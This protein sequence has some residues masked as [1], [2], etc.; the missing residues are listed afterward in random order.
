[1]ISSGA[2]EENDDDIENGIGIRVSLSC[3]F[4]KNVNGR[5]KVQ[6]HHQAHIFPK[7]R[8]KTGFHQDGFHFSLSPCQVSLARLKGEEVSSFLCGS[9]PVMAYT[10][11]ILPCLIV[12]QKRGGQNSNHKMVACVFGN[13]NLYPLSLSFSHH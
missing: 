1:M 3:L 4:A 5:G 8:W 13:F 10:I 11:I 6:V 7:R 12:Y 9:F 2:E